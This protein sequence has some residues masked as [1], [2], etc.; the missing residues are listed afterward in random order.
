MRTVWDPCSRFFVLKYLVCPEQ[1]QTS[2]KSGY[3]IFKVCLSWL[4]AEAVYDF[5]KCYSNDDQI[6]I[7]TLDKVCPHICWCVN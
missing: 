6:N 7:D 1:H 2:G 4:F 5:C 3:P